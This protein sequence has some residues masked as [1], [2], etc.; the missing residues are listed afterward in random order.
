[1]SGL[2]C[3]VVV[4]T[5][6]RPASLQRALSSLAGQSADHRSY[7]TIVVVDGPDRESCRLLERWESEGR[8]ANLSHHV[9]D[10]SGPAAARNFGCDRAR[11]PVVVFLDDDMEADAR[12]V[13]A[14]QAHHR[15]GRRIAVL[16]D[17]PIALGERPPMY[18][19]RAW[20]WWEQKLHDRCEGS[21]LP[22]YTDF[23]TGNVSLRVED[24]REVGGFDPD[25]RG[26]GLE[27]YELGWR[28][29]DAGVGFVA[30]RSARADHH[31]NPSLWTTLVRHRAEGRAEVLLGSKHPILR[32]GLRLMSLPRGGSAWTYKLA[33]G[34][35]AAGDVLAAA[36]MARL[37][38]FEKL[39]KRRRWAQL[40]E[41]VRAYWFW[42]GVASALGSLEELF[43]FQ[44]AAP[45]PPTVKVDLA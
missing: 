45:P 36:A 7:E 3:S 40:Y 42:R 11:S 2:L 1:M 33:F 15:S 22:R 34:A 28:L 25:F 32:P 35:P 38:A 16:G 43:R 27:D 20:A 9:I 24:F 29:L 17:C 26:Y 30:D 10:R 37:D 4:P 12:L 39:S 18:R 21:S 31:H 23:C 44:A 41:D 5:F 19:L 13:A 14:H 6:G 8:L